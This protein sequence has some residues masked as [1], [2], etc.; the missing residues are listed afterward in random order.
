LNAQYANSDSLKKI[1][2][3]LLQ[4]SKIKKIYY[5][6]SLIDLINNNIKKISFALLGFSI[7]LL[8][9]ALA[10][11][12]NTIRLSVYSKRFTI[13]TMQ[14]VGATKNFIRRPFIVQGIIQG[15]LGSFISILLLSGLMFFAD[16]ELPE[17]I[18]IHD[19]RIYGLLSIGIISIGIILSW[20]STYFAVNKYLKMDDDKLFQ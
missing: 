14:L 6:E 4:N 20:I 7:L 17:L 12:N 19:Y 13:K 9:I 11:I 16:K 2:Q 1:E 18:N 8:L 5:Q 3:R 15:L 10:L